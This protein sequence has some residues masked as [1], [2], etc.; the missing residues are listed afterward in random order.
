MS[1][2]NKKYKFFVGI[3]DI[4][5]HIENCHSLKDR[6]NI[7]LSLKEK[8]KNRMNVAICE[9]GDSN[10]WQRSQLAIVTCSNTKN[11]VESTLREVLEF[12]GKF[13]SVIV[14]NSESRII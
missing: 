9:F 2:P 12:I 7:L 1:A 11:I 8:I 3:C 6:R 5:L 14:L 4:D 10:L 13:P